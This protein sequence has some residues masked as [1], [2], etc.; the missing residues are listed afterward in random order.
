[1]SEIGRFCSFGQNVTVGQSKKTHP[2]DWASISHALCTDHNH[3]PEKTIIGNDVWVGE[4]A[5]IMEGLTI[6]H[7][8]IIG[9]NALVTKDVEPYQIVGGNP[10]KPIR[11]R[12]DENTR[13]SLLESKWW[14]LDLR[15]LKNLDYK[16]VENFIDAIGTLKKQAQYQTYHITRTSISDHN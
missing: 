16:N 8:A 15:D 4:G 9:R 3:L 11:Y 14:E 7:G 1:M 5:V 13:T 2:I 12:F 10:A 6:G